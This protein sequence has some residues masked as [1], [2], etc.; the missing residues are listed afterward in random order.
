MNLTEKD[1]RDLEFYA[2]THT[3][4]VYDLKVSVAK[5]VLLKL[6]SMARGSLSTESPIPSMVKETC[7]TKVKQVMSKPDISVAELVKKAFDSFSIPKTDAE[8]EYYIE[9]QFGLKVNS[10]SVRT[11]RN[12]MV[13]AGLVVPGPKVSRAG[14]LVATW[15]I[16]KG[17]D[18][19]TA[20]Q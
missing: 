20:T 18:N 5:D 16:K 13:K 11:R 10:S 17:N 1:I 19:G 7:D 15:M 9:T 2:K 8:I 14:R 6:C 4:G 12:E 3:V